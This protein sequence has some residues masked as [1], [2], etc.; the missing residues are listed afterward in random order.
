[1]V[2]DR[3]GYRLVVD[4][5]FR[6]STLDA[7]R[8]V[9][10]YLPQWSTPDRSAARYSLGDDGLT[11]RIDP[12]QPP[13]SE[14]FD[15][16]LRV[17]ALQSGVYSGPVGSS[18]GQHHF[19]DGLTVRTE[20]AMRLLWTP[21]RGIVEIRMRPSPHPRALTALWLIGTETDPRESG[22]VCVV[23]VFGGDRGD[24]E[25]GRIGVG[26]HPFGDDRLVE[27]YGMVDVP[28]SVLP[29]R[30]Y[31]VL[32][33]D[34]RCTFFVDDEP[35]ATSAQ[36]PEYPLQLMLTLYDL[37]APAESALPLEPDNDPI[38]AQI[39]WIREWWDDRGERDAV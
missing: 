26:L 25:R 17:S 33:E 5:Q 9:D 38:D 8:W 4:E 28:G 27:D 20:Q 1:M 32:I 14:E 22:E 21:R 6:G 34:E 24:S 23:E 16:D 36:A 30:T 12:D 2:L 29:W 37:P 18:D 10:H 15:G 31:G 39:A 13:W 35:V 11:L 3:S 19:R 7:Q